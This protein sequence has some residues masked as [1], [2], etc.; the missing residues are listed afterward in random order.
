MANVSLIIS[1]YN[2]IEYLKMILAALEQQT[3]KDFEVII[4]DDGSK[5]E[6]VSEINQIIIT[7]PLKIIHCWHEDK[8]FRKTKILNQ[9]IRTSK[10][11]YLIFIDGDCIPD[12]HFISD[13]F[14]NR[15]PQKVLAGR[16]VNLSQKLSDMLSEKSIRKGI[17]INRFKVLC[18]LDG[19]FGKTTSAE[20]GIRITNKWISHKINNK[21]KGILG[22]NFSIHKDDFESINGFDERYEAP[23]VGEDT[24]IDFRLKLK[25]IQVQMIK[26]LAI[27]FHIYHKKLDR[28]SA[29][30]AIF[31]ETKRTR[32][33]Y[34]PYGLIQ[35][36]NN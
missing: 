28:P 27:Q 2:K 17:L 19:L 30:Q 12:Q 29:N 22:C 10:S 20:R 3:F 14:I 16:R 21:D 1:F 9:A 31:D 15:K 32:L 23:A 25:G 8:G 5:E 4:A 11:N 13:H 33:I 26:N 24:D 34:T 6:V 35:Q 36:S 7:S 18:V